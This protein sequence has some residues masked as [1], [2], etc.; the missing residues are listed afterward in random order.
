MFPFKGPSGRSKPCVTMVE[1]LTSLFLSCEREP[2]S[3]G[4]VSTRICRN[5]THQL[6]FA[7]ALGTNG[8]NLS[9]EIDAFQ[10]NRGRGEQN[11]ISA[12]D[13]QNPYISPGKT[14]PPPREFSANGSIHVPTALNSPAFHSP[15]GRSL[16][17]NFEPRVS[18]GALKVGA[19]QAAQRPKRLNLDGLGGIAK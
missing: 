18:S 3:F 8:E 13:S 17:P 7:S 14:S 9:G 19:R 15:S 10:T 11:S 4:F 5:L 12:N 1:T 2:G 16:L 6:P